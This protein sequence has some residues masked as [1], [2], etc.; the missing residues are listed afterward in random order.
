MARYKIV[1]VGD[2]QYVQ[3]TENEFAPMWRTATINGKRYKFSASGHAVLVNDD[4][5]TTE[6]LVVNEDGVVGKEPK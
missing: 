1:E 5:E 2:R 6:I 3:S 4:L